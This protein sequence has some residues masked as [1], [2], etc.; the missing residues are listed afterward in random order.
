MKRD[1]ATLA[2]VA[3]ADPHSS[4]W[5]AANAGSGKTRVLTDRVA[6][7]LLDGVSPQRILCLTYTKAAAS[8]MQNRLFQRLGAWAMMPDAELRDS[9]GALSSDGT[10]PLD[11]EVLATARRLF[12]KAIETPGGL[13]IQTIHSFC[14]SLLRR[15]PVEAGVSPGFSE[16]DD[17][18]SKVL[19]EEVLD[20]IALTNPVAMAALARN[21]SGA[22]VD[23]FLAE[24][25]RRKELFA[26]PVSHQDLKDACGLPHGVTE[27]TILD[28]VFFGGEQDLLRDVGG[29]LRSREKSDLAL[30]IKLQSFDGVT[31]TLATLTQMEK[32]FLGASGKS[33]G[34]PKNYPP[35][36]D[37]KTAL[38]PLLDPFDALRMRVSDARPL[39]LALQ[40]Y[41]RAKDLHI[42]A[43]AYL[44]RLE[45]S[46]QRRAWLDFDDLILK[47]RTLL[48][49]SNMAAWVLFRLDGGIDHILVDEAQDTAPRQWD[50]VKLLAQ[51]FTA[52]EGAR[53]DTQRTIF[54]VGDQKQSIYSF[55]GA[56]PDAFEAMRHHFSQA[57]AHVGQRLETRDL[58]HSFRSS[59][60]ILDL[61][62]NTFTGVRGMGDQVRH[63]AFKQGLPGRVDLWS[64]EPKSDGAEDKDWFD[65]VD[66]VG[67]TH[68]SVRLAR[69]IADLI[70]R[71]LAH[72]QITEI[73][74]EDGVDVECTRRITAGDFLILVQRRSTL[75]HEIIRACK[76]QGLPMAGADRLR[77]GAELGVKDLTALLRYLAT[78]EDDLSLAAVLRSPLC[79]LTEAELFD[80]AHD[81]PSFLTT[82]LRQAEDRFPDVMQMLKD[83]R[84][85][86]DFDRPYD[87]LERALTRHNGRQKL[88]ARLGLEAEEGISALLDQAMAYEQTD[89]PSLT[90]FLEW[91]ERDEV[92]IKRQMDSAGD[93]IR[94]M[95]VH[96]AKGLEAPIVILP[97]TGKTVNKVSADI[98]DAN[99][100][101]LWK[102]RSENMPDAQRLLAEEIKARQQEERMRLLYVAM[103]RA[104]NWLIICGAGEPAKVDDGGWYALAEQGMQACGATAGATG[105]RLEHLAWPEDLKDAAKSA[106]GS[107][108][109]TA[110][111]D[112][113]QH[114]APAATAKP[115]PLSPSKLGGAKALPDPT[116]MA[117]PEE[118]AKQRGT[119]L[120]L[121]LEHL[122]RVEPKDRIELAQKLGRLGP[123][124]ED[125]LPIAERVLDAKHLAFLFAPDTMAEVSLT[126]PL[127]S[128]GGSQALG[129][130]D[131]LV[132]EPDRI[133]AVD[134]KSNTTVPTI[135]E[136]TPAG[137]LAQMGAYQEMLAQLYPDKKVE[138]A[139]LWTQTAELMVLPHDIVRQALVST[140]T[141]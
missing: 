44:P 131:R 8:E 3:A 22:D 70:S 73:K 61:V 114:K 83:L 48:T 87:L 76:D 5:L 85:R 26:T 130:I 118:E 121:L 14:A 42:F 139:I 41:G 90:G 123:D 74:R 66:T 93:A 21:F 110:L 135:A 92:T 122:P 103:T 35:T 86:T 75:F 39:R 37:A 81:R 91:L 132:I 80:L 82:A 124:G 32:L 99:G 50:V 60:A 49:D 101:A 62:D 77:I 98:L 56:D 38:G 133:L 141:S 68:H 58:L 116:G 112:W 108:K 40:S 46:K 119:S 94:V 52:G 17:R 29:V 106:S 127:P 18:T 88:L 79:G 95:T 140:H 89:V 34:L 129:I 69:K 10:V 107:Q 78:P 15:F 2:Q 104:E 20:E 33:A 96:G 120:H 105:M 64:W 137:L 117:L 30:G 111:P 36:K 59:K 113:S 43:N 12:A 27:Q 136:K 63:L 54:V 115:E 28:S 126:T 31:P 6:R 71:Q 24:L 7:L 72:G 19:R 16:M 125:L 128:L 100:V 84:D 65:P 53:V 11:A 57:L 102:E 1:D 23:D 51:E 9:L 4:T 97:D 13:K 47:A 55:Q 134:F 67:D 138:V 25:T 109:T 45:A